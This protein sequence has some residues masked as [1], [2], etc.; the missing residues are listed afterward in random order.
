M[1]AHCL[2]VFVQ[3]LDERL[4]VNTVLFLQVLHDADELGGIVFERRLQQTLAVFD[5]R[6]CDIGQR[7]QFEKLLNKLDG[8]G[9][10]HAQ[11]VWREVFLEHVLREIDDQMQFSKTSLLGV[12]LGFLD[13]RVA[14]GGVRLR[15]LDIHRLSN[16]R[17]FRSNI[18]HA[19]N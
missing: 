12:H 6:K 19:V 2:R 11:C 14:F 5:Q 13:D 15:V 4:F 1:R 17:V 16:N 7:V 18:W 3:V 10:H 8:F 9:Q